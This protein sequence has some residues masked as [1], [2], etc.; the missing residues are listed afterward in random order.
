M[1]TWTPQK[2]VSPITVTADA[3]IT[4]RSLKG[5]VMLNGSL[6][7]TAAA[8]IFGAAVNGASFLSTLSPGSFVTLFGSKLALSTQLAPTVPLPTAL[9]GS[10]IY[11]AG[12]QIPIYYA[13]DR[14]G[15]RDSALW[16]GGEHD[17]AGDCLQR[18]EPFGTPGHYGSG[19]GPGCFHHDGRA[20]DHPGHRC[21]SQCDSGGWV[22]SC[23]SGTD[24]R[25]L[26][27]GAGRGHAKHYGRDSYTG[28][29]A[30]HDGESGDGHDWGMDA[31]VAFAGLTPLQTGVVSDQRVGSGWGHDGQSGSGGGDGGGAG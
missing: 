8:P 6:T 22:E 11:V 10:T 18:I 26:L 30:F 17:P 13:S 29:A 9:A 31:P 7:A 4:D 15:E 2:V 1:G 20:G 21:E 24:D 14:T 12:N 16:P 28:V 23:D 27:H 5:E 25:D 19:S 3:S